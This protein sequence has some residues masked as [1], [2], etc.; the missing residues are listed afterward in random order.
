ME[1]DK[2]YSQAGEQG[3][4]IEIFNKINTHNKICVEFGAADGQT[5]SNT[6]F[7]VENCNWGYVYWDSARES[8]HVY[9][10]F[11]TVENVNM[12]FEKY[13]IPYTFDLLSI[14]INGNDYWIWKELKYNPR[15]VVIE[16]NP[17]IVKEKSLTIEY[18]PNFKFDKTRY[19]GA[20]FLALKKLGVLKG[21]QLVDSSR[22]NMIFVKNDICCEYN[23]E[24]YD[25]EYVAKSGWKVD[26]KQR[27]W[28]EV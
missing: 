20:S 9:K 10:E 13:H 18:N 1:N 12:I 22:M 2:D 3:K 27:K 28:I 4:L 16:F 24:K 5:H 14:D 7:F 8:R 11:I 15:V 19:Y 17:F 21:Y 6:R 25:G 26:V 23:F